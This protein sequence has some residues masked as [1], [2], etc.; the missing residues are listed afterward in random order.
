[1]QLNPTAVTTL[2]AAEDRQWLASETGSNDA[3][4]VELDRTTLLAVYTDGIVKSGTIL[5]IITTG[6][7]TARTTTAPVMVAKPLS[8]CCTTPSTSTR[9]PART[10]LP[11]C[12]TGPST[13]R[14]YPSKAVQVLDTAGTA[15]LVKFDVRA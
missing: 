2:G 1:M 14:S 4:T 11:A 8:A 9:A 12:G 15:D 13:N 3:K 10:W 5:G 7:S 6:G